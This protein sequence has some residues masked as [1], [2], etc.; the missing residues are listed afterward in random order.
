LCTASSSLC[1]APFT[2]QCQHASNQSGLHAAQPD[3]D[4]PGRFLSQHVLSAFR[5]RP[6]MELTSIHVRCPPLSPGRQIKGGLSGVNRFSFSPS[7]EC[8]E[9]WQWPALLPF[10]SPSQVFVPAWDRLC[11]DLPLDWTSGHT[12]TSQDPGPCRPAPARKE[13]PSKFLIPSDHELRHTQ[14]PTLYQGLPPTGRKLHGLFLL[15]RHQCLVR[16]QILNA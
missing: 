1:D 16:S 8:R 5:S 12:T 7:L 2:F 13:A 9:G 4:R 15:S 6:S 10:R 3:L 14:P 11:G